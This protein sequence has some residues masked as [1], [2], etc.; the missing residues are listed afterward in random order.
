MAKISNNKYYTPNDLAKRLIET[1]IKVLVENGVTDIT[2][3]IEPSAGSGA[4]SNQIKCTAY[5]IEPECDGIIKADFLEEPIEYKQGRLCI[6][7]PPFGCFVEDT[8]VYT[9]RGWLKFNELNYDD[10]CLS[11]DI[12]TKQMEWSNIDNIIKKKINE[13]VYHYY[14]SNLDLMVTK[15]HRMFAYDKFTHL[16]KFDNDD[17]FIAEN[18]PYTR[19]C[20]HKFGYKWNGV[21]KDYFILPKEIIH[22]N[23]YDKI[24]P[25]QK[26]DIKDWAKFLGLWIADGCIRNTTNSQGNQRYTI[27]IK[28]HKDT[29]DM[30]LNIC[31]KL[32]FKYRV[33]EN[34]NQNSFNIDINSK[35]LW[36]YLHQFGKSKDKWIPEYI[37]DGSTDIIKS[38]M[39]GYTFG[40][41]RQIKKYI[42]SKGCNTISQTLIEDLQICILKLGYLTNYSIANEKYQNKPYTR[43]S[44]QYHLNKKDWDNTIYYK[45]PILEQYNGFVYCVTLNKN[46]FFLVRRN[47]KICFSDNCRNSL[48]IKFYNKCCEIGD[49]IAFV[50]PISQY[51]N[52][53]QM[54]RFDLIY[55]EDLGMISY[56]DR[57]LHCCFNIYKR[58][59][60][61]QFNPK[62]DFTLKDITIIEHRRKNGDYQ[63]AANKEVDPNYDYAICN[64]G[65]GS[66]GKVPEYVGQYAQEVYLYCHKK[67]YL[68]QMLDLLEYN[69]IRKYVNSISGKKISV[70]R[71]YKYLKDN[72]EGIE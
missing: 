37:K 54:Y 13:K 63:T 6:G 10:M 31:N 41:S 30:V 39:D 61:G 53:L 49:Y 36:K 51:K 38:F 17:V 4:F 50:Q 59:D 70:M 20:I 32:P 21:D 1:T 14:S 29:L 65:N 22:Y 72:I 44:I 18:L 9:K 25:E 45:K 55:S 16:P 23:I 57:E 24:I 64:W 52:N 56:S 69:T 62:P 47:N 68:Q 48:S 19:S 67:E 58:N 43:Y 35:Q 11:V 34:K 12:E 8:E 27:S 15:D 40:D 46:G 71:L 66:L 5:D 2:D 33:Y 7:N 3:V 26:I 42:N 60:S 28:Q